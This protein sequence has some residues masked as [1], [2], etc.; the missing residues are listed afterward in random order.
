VKFLG[1]PLHPHRRQAVSTIRHN[2]KVIFFDFERIVKL[3]S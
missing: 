2:P 3:L 1:L